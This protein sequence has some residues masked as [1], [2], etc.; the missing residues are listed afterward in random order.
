MTEAI[1]IQYNIL[2]GKH[3]GKNIFRGSLIKLSKI[4][5][6]VQ[7]D[8][9][10]DYAV[11]AIFTNLKINLCTQNDSSEMT[12]QTKINYLSEDI[13]AKVTETSSEQGT[14]YIRFTAKISA[15]QKKIDRLFMSEQ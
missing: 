11:P 15:L 4:G 8:S 7:I 13:Y 2:E 10:I 6:K 1:C 12:D 9:L 5:A 14:F 3:L